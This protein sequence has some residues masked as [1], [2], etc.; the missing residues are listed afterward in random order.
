MEESLKV[1]CHGCYVTVPLEFTHAQKSND[2]MTRVW[3]LRVA[4]TT[5]T[6][7]YLPQEKRRYLYTTR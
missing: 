1:L 7:N 3:Y 5:Y 2:M 4:L 6:A